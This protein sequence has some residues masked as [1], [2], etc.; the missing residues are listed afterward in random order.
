MGKS[1]G[2]MGKRCGKGR[3]D[4]GMGSGQLPPLLHLATEVTEIPSRI[5]RGRAGA[6]GEEGGEG[7]GLGFEI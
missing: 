6:R 3:D 2:G 7:R 5:G 4:A 1:L